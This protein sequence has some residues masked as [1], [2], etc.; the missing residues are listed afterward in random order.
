MKTWLLLRLRGLQCSFRRVF[1]WSAVLRRKAHA[2]DE[3]M[4]LQPFYPKMSLSFISSI[5]LLTLPCVRT[6]LRC[7][8]DER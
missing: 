8:G 1:A 6:L 2:S 3:N 7:G 5:I 4:F